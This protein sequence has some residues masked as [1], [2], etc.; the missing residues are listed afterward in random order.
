[1]TISYPR[2]CDD[3]KRQYASKS[4]F[5][6]HKT[7][8]RCEH[9]QHGIVSQNNTG[10]HQKINNTQIIINV[11]GSD[12][13]KEEISERIEAV[14]NTNALKELRK[15]FGVNDISTTNDVIKHVKNNTSTLKEI[16][17][18]ISVHTDLIQEKLRRILDNTYEKSP[19]YPLQLLFKRIFLHVSEEGEITLK[20]LRRR[21]MRN[22]DTNKNGCEVLSTKDS[23][24][25]EVKQAHDTLVPSWTRRHWSTLIA[26]LLFFLGTRLAE[27]E[28]AEIAGMERVRKATRNVI[29]QTLVNTEHPYL[30]WWSTIEQYEDIQF[31]TQGKL[32]IKMIT[33]EITKDCNDDLVIGWYKLIECCSALYTPTILQEN[34]KG[35]IKGVMEENVALGN[36]NVDSSEEKLSEPEIVKAR[37]LRKRAIQIRND[38]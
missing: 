2:Q 3:C 25:N 14:L 19:I 27:A 4:T 31:D 5:S 33:E 9:T 32:L 26:E 35:E 29:K 34:V 15:L 37:K 6:K 13:T 16:K 10:D 8:G 28:L 22:A 17:E 30:E 11:N 21:V 1:M 20:D 7:L 12:L 36:Q 18:C 24:N 38:L 23:K